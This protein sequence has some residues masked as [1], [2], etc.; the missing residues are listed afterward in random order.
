MTRST[1]AVT[2]TRRPSVFERLGGWAYRRRWIAVALWVLVLAG[3]TVAAQAVGSDYRNDFSLPGTDSQKSLDLLEERAPVQSGESIQIVLERPAG[4]RDPATQ[5]R[6]EGMLAKIKTLPHVAGVQSPYEGFGISEQGT[7]GY[8]TVALDG[9]SAEVPADDVR[10]IIDAADAAEGEGLRVEL[11]GAPIRAA[12]EG[13][14]G[15]AEFAGMLAAL[16]IMV[17]LFGSIVAASLPLVIAIFA[18]GSAIGL[19]GLASHVATIADFTA[20]L[21]ML[22]GLGV[23]IDYALLIFSRY[24]SELLKGVPRRQAAINAQDTA[25]RTVFFAGCTVILALIGLMVLGLGSLQG[26]AVAVAM[27]VLVTML[28]SLTLLPALLSIVGGRIEKGVQKR[29]AKGKATEGTQW[30]RWVTWVQKYR[31]LNALVPLGILVA[32][33]V[34]VIN[35]NLGFADAGNDPE[36]THS[37]QAYDLL[38]EGFGPG[39]N[40]PL[41]VLSDGSPE[42]A[43]RAQ[44][45]IAATEGV[46]TAVPPN[47]IG[48]NLSLIIVL[49]ESKP[50]DQETMDLVDRLRETV[51]PPVAEETGA[52]YLIGGSTAA[53][54]DFSEAVAAKMP[55][56]VLVVVG[57]STLLLILVF[58]SLLIPLIAAVLNVL[59]VG[60]ALGIMT[61]VFQDGRLG[62]E[63]GPIEAYVP[64]MIFAVAFGLSMDYQVFLLSRMHE[65]WERSK[66][67]TEAVREGIATTGKVVTAAG[68]IMVVVFAAFMLS[69]TR[70]LQQ[71]GLGLAVAILA[72]AL[73]IGCLI[74][75]AVMQIFGRKAWWLPRFLQR[76]L[77]RVALEHSGAAHQ[78]VR[79]DEREDVR[80]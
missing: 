37:R 59:S 52:T 7:I 41:I 31:W 44:A 46:A 5:G 15:G 64:V 43:T 53:T 8:A 63:P 68:A 4:L 69:P 13:G 25:G 73:L 62:V 16:V 1:A 19:I 33:A 54:V 80:V 66:D 47:T 45:A 77:P 36:S 65:E 23:G 38:A 27:T 58:R 11:G 74:L 71:F 51:L 10:K 49:P 70:M 39:F 35:M 2:P 20:P 32:L 72:D 28:S 67:P 24:R 56:F 50:Q 3:V 30:R 40:G 29:L 78:E 60:V 42:D 17:I 48:E 61:L 79:E 76:V 75:P 57:L 26:V 55:I 14:G 12:Q 18:V 21:M 9:Q 6:V 34:P 22:V